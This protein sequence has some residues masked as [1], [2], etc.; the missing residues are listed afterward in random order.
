MKKSLVKLLAPALA[1][2]LILSSVIALAAWAAPGL[3][4]DGVLLDTTLSPG[5]TYIHT[6]TVTSGA[7]YPMDMQVEAR[8]FGQ[9]P[10][11]STIA[12]P[13]QDDDSPYTARPFIS[14]IDKPAFH[15]EPG[16]SQQVKATIN[17]PAGTAPGT[18]YAIIYISSQPG[19]K[20]GV[21]M[22][23]AA[24]VLVT[25]RILNSKPGK[26]LE[27]GQQLESIAQTEPVT[28]G[29]IINLD[30]PRPEAGK[31]IQILTTFTNTGTIHFKAKNKV[32]IT[33]EAGEVIS[34]T[35]TLLSSS[36][37]IPGL[38]RL[39]T[40]TFPLT[41]SVNDLPPGKYLV[42]SAVTLD[43]DTLLAA[44]KVSFDIAEGAEK[45]GAGEPEIAVS[46]VTGTDT[47]SALSPETASPTPVL[48]HPAGGISWSLIAII[49]TSIVAAGAV[50]IAFTMTRK[51]N[52]VTRDGNPAK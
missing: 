13:P 20:A 24:N 15:L 43:D 45:E 36:S 18:R 5:Q 40:A 30:V 28:T 52:P 39:F 8:G 35:E 10:D 27:P 37:I 3:N 11:G 31:P 50:I 51:R 9:S 23:I 33:N 42:E 48:G 29:E 4:V 19:G 22:V 26:E 46:I 6:M 21:G 14:S 49:I 41:E 12:L 2:T 34:Q 32:T 17:I 38:S 47:P 25:L 16:D 44:K 7:D 1:I